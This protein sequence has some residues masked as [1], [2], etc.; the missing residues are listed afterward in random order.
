M[1]RADATSV[2]P[3]AQSPNGCDE[4]TGKRPR[5]GTTTEEERR[6]EGHKRRQ[7]VRQ[8]QKRELQ[9]DG[10]GKSR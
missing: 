10:M 2:S 3:K 7:S 6:A 8:G 5:E 9:E 1:L 4:R